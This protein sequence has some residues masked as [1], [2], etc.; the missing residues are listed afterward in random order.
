MTINTEIKTTYNGKTYT[1]FVVESKKVKGREMITIMIED[2][3][4][5]EGIGYRSMYVDMMTQT[6]ENLFA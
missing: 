6:S 1:G 3:S 2:S 5:N 4:R